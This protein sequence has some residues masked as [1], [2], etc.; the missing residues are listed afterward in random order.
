MKV[1]RKANF[2]SNVCELGELFDKWTFEYLKHKR[3]SVKIDY[4]MT[5]LVNWIFVDE[6]AMLVTIF[7]R[8]ELYLL[9][10]R[11]Y[12]NQ[13]LISYAEK[14]MK[15]RKI[16]KT[17]RFDLISYKKESQIV[18]KVFFIRRQYQSILITEMSAIVEHDF[19]LLPFQN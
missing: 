5:C 16:R 10:G 11:V 18:C 15:H 17:M 6:K 14:I 13:V 12:F 4:S 3:Y 1:S 8:V 7:T 2:N 19:S 9:L